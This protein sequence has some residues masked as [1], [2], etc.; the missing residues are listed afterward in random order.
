MRGND[1]A[2]RLFL[3]PALKEIFSTV[4]SEKFRKR[5]DN[6]HNTKFQKDKIP[7]QENRMF[8]F[9]IAK[10]GLTLYF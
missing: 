9:M 8:H 7:V 5:Y 4:N 3:D 6:L 2:P 1:E 10:L